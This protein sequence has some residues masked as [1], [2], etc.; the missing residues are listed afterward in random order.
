MCGTYKTVGSAFDEPSVRLAL[1]RRRLEAPRHEHEPACRCG[2]AEALIALG[3]ALALLVWQRRFAATGFRIRGFV[4]E[5]CGPIQALGGLA[6]SAAATLEQG[7]DGPLASMPPPAG[8]TTT[9]TATVPTAGRA[10]PASAI[11]ATAAATAAA[12]AATNDRSPPP[13]HQLK[14]HICGRSSPAGDLHVV[15]GQMRRAGSVPLLWGQ[16]WYL[17]NLGAPMW[18]QGAAGP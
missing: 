7:L 13:P 1:C 10:G 18:R 2:L 14:H 6:F 17:A 3:A 4:F 16:P 5:S 9:T 11:V 8:V 15:D 12:A